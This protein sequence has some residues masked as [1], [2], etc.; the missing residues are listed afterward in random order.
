LESKLKQ[1]LVGAVVLVALA[2]IF[3]PMLLDGSGRS[4]PRDVAIDIPDQP[5]PPPNRLDE[6]AD[7]TADDTGAATRGTMD[8]PSGAE[9][10]QNT[11][12]EQPVPSSD[13]TTASDPP[14]TGDAA[15]ASAAEP[16]ESAADDAANGSATDDAA[17]SAPERA[18]ETEDPGPDESATAETEATEPPADEADSPAWVVQVGSFGRETNAVVLRDRLR[19]LGFDTFIERAD[20]DQGALWRV[21]VGPVSSEDKAERLSERVTDERGGPALVMTQP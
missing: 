17:A 1:R 11:M 5:Q 18:P 16:S 12:S 9:P 6:S 8:S 7:A 13:G 4:G 19:E 14:S 3:L 21:R 2:I 20:T 10:Q 15:A